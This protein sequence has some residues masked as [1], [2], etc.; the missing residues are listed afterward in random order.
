MVNSSLSHISI[1]IVPTL[2]N[3][4]G[5]YLLF[6]LKGDFP[7]SK[8]TLTWRNL[9]FPS[10]SIIWTPFRQRSPCITYLCVLYQTS[11]CHFNLLFY[12]FSSDNFR[13]HKG[14]GILIMGVKV[15]NLLF[16]NSLTSLRCR[17]LKIIFLA[18]LKQWNVHQSAFLHS[19]LELEK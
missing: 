12:F 11:T 2:K 15:G 3:F 4:M 8:E 1:L 10:V 18:L 17:F 6:M 19:E 13:V 14:F 9:H 7:S 16:S 5:K